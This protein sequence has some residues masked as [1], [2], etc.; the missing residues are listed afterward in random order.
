ML[1]LE[2]A[3]DKDMILLLAHNLSISHPKPNSSNSIA[4]GLLPLA[5]DLLCGCPWLANK[6]AFQNPESMAESAQTKFDGF[7][8]PEG[9]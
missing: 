1:F 5:E 3:Q 6:K 9:A 7:M 4:F 2:V 8:I